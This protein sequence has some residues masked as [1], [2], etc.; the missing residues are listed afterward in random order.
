M[1]VYVCSTP[2]GRASCHK[3]EGNDHFQHKRYHKAVAAYTAGVKEGVADPT[4]MAILH[5]NR[6]AAQFHL[7]RGGGGR[8]GVGVAYTVV[9]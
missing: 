4:L 2:E 3:E 1:Y 6:A 9:V 7:G 5:T 8:Q